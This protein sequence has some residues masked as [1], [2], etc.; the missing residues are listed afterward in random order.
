MTQTPTINRRGW[1]AL[2]L[3]SR[4]RGRLVPVSP[5]VASPYDDGLV[6]HFAFEEASGNRLDDVAAAAL[7]LQAGAVGTDFGMFGFGA[8]L[9]G[10]GWLMSPETDAFSP[11]AQGFAVSVWANFAGNSDPYADS[12]FGVWSDT[13]WPTG[14]SWLLHA[15]PWANAVNGQ[16]MSPTVGYDYIGGS[17]DLS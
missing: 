5:A 8:N 17:A 9:T 13:T 2:Y 16:M 7:E 15:S 1:L 11:T 4:R 10:T 14:A 6:A 12:Y 3:Q